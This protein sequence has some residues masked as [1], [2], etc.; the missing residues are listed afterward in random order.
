MPKELDNA[1][2]KLENVE[3]QL[4]TAKAEVTKPFAQETELKEKLDRLSA[5]NALLN[6]DETG[7]DAQIGNE[8]SEQS[9]ADTLG[10]DDQRAEQPQADTLGHSDQRQELAGNIPQSVPVE[11]AGHN[12]VAENNS[13]HGIKQREKRRLYKIHK[14]SIAKLLV[15]S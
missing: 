5:L 1:K 15:K 6:M 3:R 14:N 7:N 11:N 8:T 9:D 12:H 4:E 13:P 10:H 2:V